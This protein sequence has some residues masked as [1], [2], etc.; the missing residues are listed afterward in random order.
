MPF[1]RREFI[2]A[3]PAA[4]FPA[5][6]QQHPAAGGQVLWY[7][8]PASKWTD[9]LP[10]GNGRSGAMVFGGIEAERIQL[11]DDSFWSGA[12]REW[13]N[14]DAKNH[15]AE[16]RRLVLEKEDYAAADKVCR[17]MQGPYTESYL[18]LADLRLAFGGSTE[19]SNYRRELDLD[20]AVARVTFTRDGTTFSREVFA[21]APDGVLAIRI[22]ATRPGQISFS[23]SI[24][25]PVRGQA[26]AAGQ[27]GLRFAGKAPSHVDPNYLR[28][29]EPVLYD[30]AEG[31]GMRFEARVEALAEGGKVSAAAGRLQVSGA[32]AVTLLIATATGY[33]GYDRLPDK[34]ADA[35]A[36][37]CRGRLA[38][39]SAR[40]I[41]ELKSRHVADYQRLFRR[42]SLDLGGGSDLPTDERLKAFKEH[43]DPQLLSLYFQYGRY[44]L[45]ASSRVGTQPANLQGIWNEEVRPPWSSNW[46]ANIN[47]QMNYWPAEVCNLSE[48][49]QPLF[50]LIDGLAKNGSRTAEINYGARGWV[51]HH[52]VDIWRQPA[53]V[54]NYGQGSPTWANWPMSGPWFCQHLWDH[55]LFTGDRAFLRDRAYPLMKGAAQFC[56]DF[57]IEDT[58]GHLT[59]C[60]SVSTE[61][62]FITPEGK[63]AEVSAGCTMDMALIGEIFSNCIEA[64]RLLGADA[65]FRGSLERA[66][67]RLVPYRTG[68]HGQLQEWYKDFDER[69]PGH[70]HMSHMYGLY[71]GTDITPRRNRKIWDAARISLERRLKAGGAYT[72]WS[73]AWAINFWARLLD[74]ERAHESLVMLMLHSTGPNLFDTHPAGQS[75]IFQIDGN[76]GATAAIAE[77]LLQSHDGAIEFLP[78]LPSMWPRGRVKGLRARGGVGVG[79]EWANGRA[80]AATLVPDNGGRHTLRAPRQQRIMAVTLSGNKV[81]IAQAAGDR[82]ATVELGPQAPYRVEFA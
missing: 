10:V 73:R 37:E 50:D 80:T 60:P 82:E 19:V 42:V 74:G 43:P 57:L 54:G 48:L 25:S 26:E 69:E 34:S 27:R 58:E 59:T 20:T 24:D 44:L 4:V 31:K 66:K 2:A 40:S 55:Y 7:K 46:T 9:A 77:M 28:S 32:H 13:N 33:R 18:V 51:S 15:L 14:P 5:A 64:S 52:N 78:A 75:Q 12:P 61:N 36:A 67:S 6:A 3:F 45:I 38:A 63:P 47:V 23:A 81:A 17:K 68:K 41:A 1:S 29:K 11:N 71:P 62:V 56:L 72:G 53:A 30:E 16:V 22:T 49:H 21:S 70:R 35:I 8:Q 65:K 39:A 76:F 79:I